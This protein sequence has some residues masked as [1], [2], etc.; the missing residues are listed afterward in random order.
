MKFKMAI[1]SVFVSVFCVM[2]LTTKIHDVRSK[3]LEASI[4][5]ISATPSGLLVA[6]AM[7]FKGVIADGMFL[8]A[9]N[10]I[11]RKSMERSSPTEDEWFAFYLLLDRTTDL[12]GRFLD[13][14]VFA[15][16]ML[17][18]Q[19]NDV[20]KANMLLLKGFEHRP[21]DWTLP[22]YVGFNYFFFQKDYKAG[23]KYIVS[24]ANIPGS[25]SYFPNLAARLAYYGS[26][27]KTALFFLEQMLNENV[28]IKQNPELE[29]R[30]YALKNASII[31]DSAYEYNVAV[32]NFPANVN[33]LLE[34][35]YLE[36]CPIEPYGGNWTIHPDGRVD[37]T[38]GFVEKRKP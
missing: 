10:F 1:C 9:S 2:L 26:R 25:P 32:G 35:G 15:E 11:G 3:Y 30:L 13:P 29:K 33:I 17:A 12:D 14:Y 28:N 18:W 16:M 5:N 24:A 4:S 19:A 21:F 38:S 37:S 6:V 7:E 22:Y 27:S 31:E 36:D 20:D 8:N 23:A 34:K